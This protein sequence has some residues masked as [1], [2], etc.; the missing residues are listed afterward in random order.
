M[1]EYKKSRH[2]LSMCFCEHCDCKELKICVANLCECCYR[3]NGYSISNRSSRKKMSLMQRF[4]YHWHHPRL[5]CVC[6]SDPADTIDHIKPLKWDG[7]N[8]ISNLQPMCQRCN[9]AKG[10]RIITLEDLR[11]ELGIEEVYTYV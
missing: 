11:E 3:D 4:L 8:E 7:T 2:G 6:C 10:N 9:L 1:K 5:I